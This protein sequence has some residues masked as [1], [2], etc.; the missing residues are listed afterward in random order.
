[1]LV[2][3]LQINGI[4]RHDKL[5]KLATCLSVLDHPVY[6]VSAKRRH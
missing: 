1:M 5:D 6:S 2:F 3:F 4:N